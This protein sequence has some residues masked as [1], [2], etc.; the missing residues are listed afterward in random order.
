MRPQLLRASAILTI[1]HNLK[2]AGAK[3][4]GCIILE[5][6]TFMAKKRLKSFQS[7]S[8]R[9]RRKRLRFE[10]LEQRRLLTLWTVTDLSDVVAV[11]GQVTLREAIQAA[12]TNAPVNEAI[13]GDSIGLDQ[14]RFADELFENGPQVF[15]IEG[16]IGPLRAMGELA[17]IGPGVDENGDWLLALDA[18]VGTQVIVA[19]GDISVSGVQLQ[20]ANGSALLSLSGD[21]IVENTRFFSNFTEH[22][23]GAIV[24]NGDI[25]TVRDSVFVSNRATGDGGAIW[26]SGEIVI[27][28]S[29][30]RDSFSAANGG[31]IASSDSLTVFGSTFVGNDASGDG[32]AIHATFTQ[33][34]ASDQARVFA[35]SFSNNTSEGSGGAIFSRFSSNAEFALEVGNSVFDRNVAGVNGG[36]ISNQDGTASIRETT[37]SNNVAMLGGGID[38]ITD[39]LIQRSTLNGNVAVDGGAV[40]SHGMSS[41]TK[42]NIV[43]TTISGN[44]ATNLGGGVHQ[45]EGELLV[46]NSTIV[47]NR[48]DADNDGTGDGG[49]LAIRETETIADTRLFNTIVA[50]N[51]RGQSGPSITLDNSQDGAIR[52]W[53]TDGLATGKYRLLA[54]WVNDDSPAPFVISDGNQAIAAVE[55]D[56]L[57][58]PVPHVVKNELDFESL[59]EFTVTSGELVIQHNDRLSATLL[60]ERVDDAASSNDIHMVNPGTTIDVEKS[61]HNLIGNPAPSSTGG[62]EDDPNDLGN[63]NFVGNFGDPWDINRIIFTDLA[64]NLGG[65]TAVHALQPLS[66]AIDEGSPFLLSVGDGIPF[67]DSD[68]PLVGTDPSTGAVAVIQSDGN[69]GFTPRT[70]IITAD[71]RGYPFRRADDQTGINARGNAVDI[72]A[73]EVQ[74]NP[75]LRAEEIVVSTLDTFSDGDFSPGNLSLPEAV[76]IANLRTDH[77]TIRFTESLIRGDNQIAAMRLT[78]PLQIEFDTTIAG[79]GAN[80]LAVTGEQR[81]FRVSSVADFGLSGLLLGT[82]SQDARGDAISNS[83]T[84]RLDEVVIRDRFQPIINN[85]SG[86]LFVSNSQIHD[87]A[88]GAIFNQGDLTVG[89]SVEIY[90][91]FS[92][93]DGAGI[94]SQ[95]SGSLVI[96]DSIIRD[97]YSEERGGGL[98]SR[99]TTTE[100]RR[101]DVTDNT[102]ENGG[103]GVTIDFGSA[104]IIDTT[105]QRNTSARPDG[106]GFLVPGNT[107]NGGGVQVRLLKNQS[108]EI[109]RSTISDNEVNDPFATPNGGGVYFEAEDRES[110]VTIRSSTISRNTAS[111]LAPS[112]AGVFGNGQGS[113]VI[114]SSTI[115]FNDAFDMQLGSGAGAGAR[116]LARDFTLNN[117]LVVENHRRPRLPD[118]E[119]GNPRFGE[120]D[121]DLFGIPDEATNNIVGTGGGVLFEPSNVFGN[122]VLGAEPSGLVEELNDNGGF[123]PTHELGP[124]SPAIDSGERDGLLDQRGFPITDND[125]TSTRVDQ[126]TI[127]NEFSLSDFEA[128]VGAYESSEIFIQPF[129]AENR[130]RSQFDLGDSAVIGV[131]Y[132]DGTPNSV[133]ASEPGFLGLELDLD[134]FVLG[135]GVGEGFFGDK[136]GGQ[137]TADVD[138]RVGFEY[139]YY[140]NTGSV[141]TFYDGLFAYRVEED[142]DTDG[143]FSI[144]TGAAIQD[145]ALYTNSPNL[146]AYVDLV[147]EFNAAIRGEACFVWCASGG[148][149]INID[150]T[151]P[152]FSINRQKEDDN[153]NLLF[154]DVQG[155]ETTTRN[156]GNSPSLDGEIMY[157]TSAL[158]DIV[159]GIQDDAIPPEIQAA[160][161]GAGGEANYLNDLRKERGDA[162]INIAGLERLLDSIDP[163]SI[164]PEEAA[165][166]ANA[167]LEITNNRNKIKDSISNEKKVTAKPRIGDPAEGCF[168]VGIVAC[169]GQAEGDLLGAQVDLAVG[170]QIGKVGIGKKLGSLAV[171]LPEIK[172]SDTEIDENGRLSATTD[173]FVVGSPEDAKRQL[174]A[175][176]VDVAAIGP[177]GT[178]TADIGPIGIEATTVSY[179]ITPRFAVSQDVSVEPFFDENHPAS[180]TFSFDGGGT[181]D[182]TIGNGGVRTISSGQSVQFVPGAKLSVNSGGREVTVVP[183]LTVGNRFSNRLGFDFDIQGSLEVLALQLNAFGSEVF[184]VGPLYRE[185]HELLEGQNL[186]DLFNKTFNLDPTVTTLPEFTIGG[187]KASEP[188]DGGSPGSAITLQPGVAS[189]PID[190]ADQTSTTYFSVPQAGADGLQ[191]PDIRIET[192]ANGIE[193]IRPPYAGLT[194]E[195]INSSTTDGVRNDTA[196]TRFEIPIEGVNLAT[197]SIPGW[198][199]E[200]LSIRGFEYLLGGQAIFGLEFASSNP[201]ITAEAVGGE[202]LSEFRDFE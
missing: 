78:E 91:N 83:G 201:E 165:E 67:D 34:L 28:N 21:V 118:D 123:T 182:V 48:S 153:G 197:L 42:T 47:L 154:E 141:D 56:F 44:Y 183:E 90:E 177:L 49:G 188:G 173:D 112:G 179:N 104:F 125:L 119:A 75:L 69:G 133:L 199:G 169:F 35:S 11:D 191:R 137:A 132:D 96:F 85:P 122:I 13:A 20:R 168:G 142:P 55:R 194:L 107:P 149:S 32:G 120:Q 178:Y 36:A 128:D 121:E 174:A 193:L 54:R 200:V 186:F 110:S 87:N 184:K 115:A 84:T 116:V 31:A 43:N 64:D 150:Q 195:L 9:L 40:A 113:S 72:G 202:A 18:F 45:N 190:I 82:S 166:A 3:A 136:Y 30:F 181:I 70:D 180:F 46:T 6:T 25:L 144:S 106:N 117:S 93:E 101:S 38:T 80:L 105:I 108:L 148:F 39:L 145:G 158:S 61:F 92:R 171:T 59:G 192:A 140:V 160:R 77:N 152:L 4:R 111:G 175:L 74:L 130:N 88:G 37:L 146:G 198:D 7:K 17:I 23:G 63:A 76:A 2:R 51:L 73:F 81:L 100:I 65:A 26:S 14:I 127:V 60:I 139:G 27:Q 170:A 86:K 22:N 161:N 172:L 138:A 89:P 29:E 129:S 62:L 24:H 99:S 97:N 156:H 53:S 94:R 187:E 52:R 167:V 189:G 95:G 12:A 33:T 176:S 5:E 16:A 57:R 131:G 135:P 134:P 71:Q 1:H 109:D 10:S 124:I 19:E 151:E 185:Q 68:N 114:E 159:E 15:R 147:F 126:P 143:T 66:P 50:G 8:R 196:I 157:S 164:D 155:R 162:E 163:E 102:S 98:Y 79:P 58:R 103:G 41:T